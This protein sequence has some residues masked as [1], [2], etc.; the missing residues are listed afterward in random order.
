MNENTMMTPRQTSK[1][2]LLLVLGVLGT[3]FLLAIATRIQQRLKP[4]AVASV[5]P[6]AVRVEVVGPLTYTVSRSYVGTVEAVDRVVLSAEITGRV[7]SVSRREGQLFSKGQVLVKIDDEEESR[8]LGRLRAALRR[9]QADLTFWEN[10]LERDRTLFKG[11]SI[12]REK[13]DDT[14]RRV[15]G[16]Q[17]SVQESEQGLA[18]AGAR[19]AYGEIRAPFAGLVQAVMIH[20]GELAVAGRPL[21]ELVGE[22][23]LKAV[24]NVPQVDLPELKVGQPV[25]VTEPSLN[26]AAYATEG[27]EGARGT[28]VTLAKVDRVYPALDVLSRTATIEAFLP[29]NELL[30]PGMVVTLDVS[31][32][33][34][35]DA[36]LVPRQALRTI[37][38]EDGVFLAVDGAAVWRP[39]V[40][41]EAQAGKVEVMSGLVAGDAVITTPNPQLRDGR[42]ILVWEDR[43]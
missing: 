28:E 36:F 8:E 13:L 37:G 1:R 30:R 42:A 18:L 32:E 25:K 7:L 16:L 19:R 43:T 26:E 27:T 21:L 34:K 41:G 15:E 6:L 10:Q 9:L 33:E 5:P 35:T 12:S 17:A 39:V 22:D 38:T 23:S 2:W 11:N 40:Q 24:A 29:S 20:P 31:L 14:V 4:P 3:L